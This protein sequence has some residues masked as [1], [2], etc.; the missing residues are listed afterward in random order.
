MTVF[1]VLQHVKGTEHASK[2]RK[3]TK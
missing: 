2:H 3:Q 1:S